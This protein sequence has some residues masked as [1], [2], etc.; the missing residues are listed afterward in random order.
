MPHRFGNGD[1]RRSSERSE[2]KSV[3]DPRTQWNDVDQRRYYVEQSRIVSTRY[4]GTNDQITARNNRL[5]KI[6]AANNLLL[7]KG[8]LP[9]PNGSLL[10]IRKAVTAKVRVE[11][12]KAAPTKGEAKKK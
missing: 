7:I 8:A 3:A 10:F 2:G 12:E 1:V 9:G 4:Y 6:D 5:L 11:A